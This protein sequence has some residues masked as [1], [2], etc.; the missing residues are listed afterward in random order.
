[1]NKDSQE[2]VGKNDVPE[3]VNKAGRLL[4]RTIR[5]TEDNLIPGLISVFNK[6][7]FRKLRILYPLVFILNVFLAAFIIFTVFIAKNNWEGEPEKMFIVKKGDSFTKVTAELEKEGFIR[8]G[9]AF[10]LAAKFTG[11]DDEV[12]PRKYLLK[13]GMSNTEILELISNPRIVQT[14]KFRVPEGHTIKKISQL[15]EARFLIPK[16]EFIKATEDRE[17]IND[18]GLGNKV[19]NLEGFLYPDTY[20]MSINVDSEDIVGILVKEFKKKVL[21]NMELTSKMNSRGETLLEVVTMASIIE[22]ETYIEEEMPIISGVYHNRLRKRMRLEA[23]PTI[24]YA[25]PD[26]PKSRLLYEDLRIDSPY[27]TY[28]NYGLP[29]GPINN[30]GLDAI[31]AAV[32][33]ASHNYIFFVATGEGGHTFSETYDEHKRKASEYRKKLN[34]KK[35]NK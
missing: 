20:I 19:K 34:E 16:E 35:K 1:M 33:P 4:K 9:F 23:D 22:G 26:G 32:N 17:V 27:N 6:I 14:V 15:V 2:P 31:K 13:S 18:L 7:P 30:P 11:S 3:F 29:P 5:Y 10:K 25:L 21:D 12:I 24:Q 8:N 28:R